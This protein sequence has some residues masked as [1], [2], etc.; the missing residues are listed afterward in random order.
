MSAK[1]IPNLM[2]VV[3]RDTYVNVTT[4]YAT[5][6]FAGAMFYVTDVGGDGSMWTNSAGSIVPV[7]PITLYTSIDSYGRAP[8]GTINTGSSGNITFGTAANRT[9]TEGLYVYLPSIATTPA[10]TAGFYWCVMSSTTVGT[11]YASKDGAAINFTVGASYTGVTTAVDLPLQTLK[12]GVMGSYRRLS[13]T[14]ILSLTNNANAK[15]TRI[16]FGGSGAGYN[17]FSSGSS[18]PFTCNFQNKG[19]SI[20]HTTPTMAGGGSGG[21]TSTLAINTAIDQTYG[22]SLTSGGSTAT[23]WWI[24][25]CWQA[26][27]FPH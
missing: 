14:G 21:S 2:P 12:G 11:L 27:L 6:A 20:Q 3:V 9:Y 4:N 26:V 16:K 5:S 24:V 22:P 7:A 8:T 1:A 23:D 19:P 10:I 17:S 15:Q 25:D 18:F 13:V